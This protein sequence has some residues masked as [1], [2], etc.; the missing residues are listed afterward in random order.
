[1]MWPAPYSGSAVHCASVEQPPQVLGV[2][3]AQS[4]PVGQS[5]LEP[6]QSPAVHPPEMQTV[7]DPYAGSTWHATSLPHA[8]QVCVGASQICPPV[9][10]D[11]TRHWPGMQ[12]LPT[13]RCCGPK[14]VTQAASLLHASQRRVVVLQIVPPPQSAVD[15]HIPE[16]QLPFMQR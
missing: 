12:T 14:A 13:H 3:I 6:W 7:D 5:A 8:W 10:S 2:S 9:Q 11:D 15:R 4:W 16:T 1:Q